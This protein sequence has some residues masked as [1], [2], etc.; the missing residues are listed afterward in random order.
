MSFL[1]LPPLSQ[2]VNRGATS[3][4]RDAASPRSLYVQTHSESVPPSFTP[5]IT[6][7]PFPPLRV[8]RCLIWCHPLL[9]PFISSLPLLTPRA[10][11]P[12][13]DNDVLIMR[14]LGQQIALQSHSHAGENCC[15]L[16][17]P[18]PAARIRQVDI[19]KLLGTEE[20]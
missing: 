2:R 9:P 15:C 14:L 8:L 13:P 4:S 17:A 20:G 19:S 10:P 5:Q 12:P 11:A 1:S 6:N 18:H 7:F 3:C 16:G